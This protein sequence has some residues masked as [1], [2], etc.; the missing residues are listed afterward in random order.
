MY[1]LPD[2][3]EVKALL[4]E[5][6]GIDGEI[7]PLN[8]ELDFNYMITVSEHPAYL[9]K[10]TAPGTSQAFL[11]FQ[12]ALLKHL[13]GKEL[14]TSAIIPTLE[15]ESV[16]SLT[17]GNSQLRYFRLMKWMP[18]RLWSQVNP[19]T[20]TLRF[21]LGKAAGILTRNLKGFEHPEAHRTLEWDIAQGRWTE[22]HTHLFSGKQKE[23]IA[24]FQKMFRE[25]SESYQTLRKA[26]VHNDINDNNIVVTEDILNPEVTALIDLGDAVH[27]QIINDLAVCCVY[28]ITECH[29]PLS[30]TI[31]II[32][33]YHQEFPLLEEE[34]EHLYMAIGM[35]M[36][37]SLAKSAIN[38]VAEPDNSYLTISEKP[39]WE[40]LQKWREVS[41]EFAHYVFRS[42]CGFTPHPKEAMFRKW[43]A[44]KKISLQQLFPGCD[45]NRILPLD[46]SIAGNWLGLKEDYDDPEYF[47]FRIRQL[48]HEDPEGIIAGGYLEPRPIY[49]TDEYV[50][51]G[52]HGREYRTIHLGI[53][54]WLP[55]G[56][57]VQAVFDGE[58]VTAYNDAGDKEYG[59]LII[60]KHQ[61][62]GLEFY[63]LYGH[64]S[65]ESLNY[66]QV[67][68]RIKRGETFAWLGGYPENGN[69][70]PHLHFQVMLSMLHYTIDFPGV[71]YPDQKNVW[72]SMCPDPNAFFKLEELNANASPGKENIWSYRR[73]HLGK[74]MSLQYTEPLEI[75]RGN[76]VYLMDKE[77]RQYLD[78][79]NNVAHLG[80]EHPEVVRAGQQQ[81]AVLNTNTRYLN[82]HINNLTQVLLDTLPGSLSV[83]HFV[84]SG[85]E[86]NELALRMAE[87]MTGSKH[88]LVSEIGYHGNTNRCIEV[89]SYKFDGKGG[90]GAPA[91]THVFPLPDIFRGKYRGEHAPKQYVHEVENLL[92]QMED[93]GIQPAGLILEPIISCGGQ[94]ELPE[95]F[96]A[97]VYTMV[98]KRGGIC[99]SD[100][101]QTGCGR[102]GEHFWGFQLH[103]VVPDIVTIG[104][105]LG[106][107]HPV[108]AVACTPEVAEKFANGMEYF[109]TFG[110]NPVSCAI[111]AKVIE[112]VQRDELQN[113]ARNMGAYL[114]SGLKAL[115]KKY[116]VIGDI[117][118]Q[119]LFLGV[120]L[121]DSRMS[122]L[123]AQ[124]TYL[125]NRMKD[126]KILMSTDG[127]DHNV[128][129][130]KPPMIF[131]KE[132]AD[133]VLYYLAKIFNEDLM[134]IK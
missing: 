126:H 117:R 16:G 15:Q 64:L 129:K 11:D 39:L 120:E 84:N 110:G 128:I 36:V 89:S 18:G 115:Q 82:E 127:A 85:S 118:G 78:T 3:E 58:V 59:G 68:D 76:G 106:N 52:N 6:Y 98:R 130:I 67:G 62:D 114:K 55:A 108:A 57:A 125:V 133:E 28:A 81:M 97:E 37:I 132:N 8:G 50:K 29:D 30:A 35:R 61:E 71:T 72:G 41:P 74:G 103:G 32:R 49:T 21:S 83:L 43:V 40:L 12:V 99:I 14:T 47:D 31:P 123:E 79:V 42:A 112:V 66:K 24:Y 92:N 46:L 25:H 53:D 109:N 93:K 107:G 121:V 10:I 27:T 19:V 91:H 119:G 86:A 105:P 75:V 17:D 116:P 23:Y 5:N 45:K 134:K 2:L 60:L 87:T 38:K 1:K 4:L 113:H 100:E 26:V 44:G 94:V 54:F 65:L 34:L 102:T 70:A 111:A 88:M 73:K 20:E 77:G 33:G 13:N 56:T 63:T 22:K 80:H 48:Q 101:V 104:K 95:G 96:L 69:W 124:A 7:T 90:K 51:Q 131:N 9:F 122:P